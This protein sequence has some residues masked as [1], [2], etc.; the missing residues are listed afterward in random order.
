MQCYVSV[1]K[2]MEIVTPMHPSYDY[3]NQ[4]AGFRPRHFIFYLFYFSFW[5]RARAGQCC[6]PA[7]SSG[8][9]G[10]QQPRPRPAARYGRDGYAK[11]GPARWAQ[12]P[13]TASL[14]R[15]MR[16]ST[17]LTAHLENYHVSKRRGGSEFLQAA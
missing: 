6:S 2:A 9:A 4:S 10:R 1:A 12:S 11:A 14:F 13:R 3:S 17:G 16:R 5:S 8:D 15:Q 7:V